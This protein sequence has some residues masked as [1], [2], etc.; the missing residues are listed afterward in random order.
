ML[1]SDT[2]S[3]AQCNVAVTSLLMHWSYC[4][5]VLS[6]RYGD[7]DLGQHRTHGPLARY[8][9]LRVAH[10]PGTFPLAQRVSDPSMHHGMCMTHVPWCMSGS[11]TS[12]FLWSRWRGKC[13]R[14]SRRVCNPQ[15]Y[16]SHKRPMKDTPYLTFPSQVNCVVSVF[17]EYCGEK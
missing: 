11:C 7:V 17:C 2:I 1:P 13:S 12:G 15:F 3:M 9:K 16:V 4:S 8:I 14:H 5:H 6:H 10:V